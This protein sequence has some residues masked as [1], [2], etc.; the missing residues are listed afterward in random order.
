MEKHY[1]PNE[2]PNLNI[3]LEKDVCHEDDGDEY[4]TKIKKNDTI[5]EWFDLY[6]NIDNDLKDNSI[7]EQYRHIKRKEYEN[8]THLQ[9]FQEMMV[10]EN[11]P[12]RLIKK[13]Y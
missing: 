12:W 13:Y 8:L 6:Q 7:F 9:D 5:F 1:D 11:Y 10:H 4:N 2:Q 3:A